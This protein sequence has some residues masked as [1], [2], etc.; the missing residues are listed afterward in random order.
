MGKVGKVIAVEMKVVA[1]GKGDFHRARV[2]LEAT[3]P[4]V[5]FVTLAPEGCE[6]MLLQVKYEK[7]PRFC[8]HCGL[9]GHIHL[10]CGSGEFADDDLQ[11]G[12]W[13]IASGDSWRA[14]TPRVRLSLGA[15]QERPPFNN[16]M[17]GERGSVGDRRRARGMGGRFG[18]GREGMWR[19]KKAESENSGG[20]RKRGSQE[21]GF[22]GKDEDL[23]D[24]ASSPA[25]HP[26]QAAE[27]K[28]GG[29]VKKKLELNPDG[30]P[31]DI[32]PPPPPQYVSPREKKKKQKKVEEVPVIKSL[33]KAASGVEDRLK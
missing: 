32:V 2:E 29:S 5:R 3:K 12:D 21:A 16:G 1:S 25:K 26:Q 33:E 8:A 24:S 28:V 15:E 6:P 14:G 13:M 20:S 9:M 30:L 19:E 18:G 31:S 7:M 10:E 22:G 4:L 27:E 11:F 23:A 17:K